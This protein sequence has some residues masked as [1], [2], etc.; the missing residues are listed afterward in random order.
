[1]PAIQILCND[2]SFDENDVGHYKKGQNLTLSAE[3]VTPQAS[4]LSDPKY[5]LTW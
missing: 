5:I 1:M 3:W 2:C 4:P